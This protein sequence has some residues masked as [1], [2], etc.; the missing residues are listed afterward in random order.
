MYI[1]AIIQGY[2]WRHLLGLSVLNDGPLVL[3]VNVSVI[4]II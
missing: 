2:N 3:Q 4:G 1:R